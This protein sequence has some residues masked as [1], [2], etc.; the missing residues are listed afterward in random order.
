VFLGSVLDN[1]KVINKLLSFW[2]RLWISR[3]SNKS[4][5][6]VRHWKA[7]RLHANALLT[8]D[9]CLQITLIFI[10]EEISWPI[11][12][13]AY[14]GIDRGAVSAH[15]RHRSSLGS[16][17]PTDRQQCNNFFV[18]SKEPIVQLESPLLRYRPL[19]KIYPT[20]TMWQLRTF[21]SIRSA[22]VPPSL[23]SSWSLVEVYVSTFVPQLST[24]KRQ[25]V[26]L[27]LKSPSIN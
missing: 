17:P 16:P 4:I 2:V 3:K 6:L 19:C 15:I 24:W 13:I 10:H 11:I 9:A 20:V 7:F 23:V 14:F 18:H 5:F 25:I 21:E 8:Y 1:R 27:R 26:V 12:I 22:F